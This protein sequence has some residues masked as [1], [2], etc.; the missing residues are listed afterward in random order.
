MAD[1]VVDYIPTKEWDID[2]SSLKRFE[3][4]IHKNKGEK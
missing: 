2:E 3:H 4:F 1:P